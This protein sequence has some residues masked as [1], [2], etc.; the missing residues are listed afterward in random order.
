MN[1]AHTNKHASSPRP[2]TQETTGSLQIPLLYSNFKSL[3]PSFL[4]FI[5]LL[6]YPI[7]C[8]YFT[9]QKR[10]CIQII[11]KNSSGTHFLHKI[12]WIEIVAWVFYHQLTPA[13]TVNYISFATLS[14]TET[15]THHTL[16][17]SHYLHHSSIPFAHRLLRWS[18]G[19]LW[20]YHLSPSSMSATRVTHRYLFRF[21][22]LQPFPSMWLS[23]SSHLHGSECPRCNQGAKGSWSQGA[24][25]MSRHE[26]NFASILI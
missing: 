25:D 18:F 17:N 5:S 9:P 23:S 24:K 8:L 21:S 11:T 14:S 13:T 3:S 12:S 4:I 7:F 26:L 2:I 20:W 19:W 10:S 1:H 16:L 22:P 15:A 6:E